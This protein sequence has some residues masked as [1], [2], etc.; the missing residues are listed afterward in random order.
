MYKI[1]NNGIYI[2]NAQRETYGNL[3]VAFSLAGVFKRSL[4]NKGAAKRWLIEQH[5]KSNLS[6]EAA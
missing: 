3:W 5:Q 4:K 6:Q 2:G 1:F